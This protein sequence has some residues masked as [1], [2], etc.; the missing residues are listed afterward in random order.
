MSDKIITKIVIYSPGF[1]VNSGGNSITHFLCNYLNK[2]SIFEA[3]LLPYNNDTKTQMASNTCA[4]EEFNTN[5]DLL[6]IKI[7]NFEFEINYEQDFIVYNE[8]IYGNPLNF[9]NVVRWIL[10]FPDKNIYESF[11]PDDIILFYVE[12]Y[13]R[14]IYELSNIND[15]SF[16][17]IF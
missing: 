4:K 13:L 14:N 8:S 3:Y 1:N 9:T 7:Y 16:I 6:N 15:N 11:L 5:K 2:Y 17:L 12:P 10:Y